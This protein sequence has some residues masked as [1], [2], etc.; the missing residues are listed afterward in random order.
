MESTIRHI[1]ALFSV[2]CV[3]VGSH[4]EL[5][6]EDYWKSVLANSPMPRA[7]KDLLTPEW[8]DDKSTS[9]GVTKGGVHVSTGHPKSGGTNVNVGHGSVGVHTGKPGHRTNVGVGKG[10]VTVGTRTRKGKPVYVRVK[11]GYSPFIYNYAATETQLHD[12]PNVALFFLEKDLHAGRKMNLQF[13]KTT[14]RPAFLSRQVAESMPFS[15]NK[16]PEIL[17]MFSLNPASQEAETVKKTIEE[18]E[19]KGVE[20]EKKVC[21]TSLESMVDFATSRLGK[22]VKAISTEA[23]SGREMEYAIVGVKKLPNERGL[24]V[25]HRQE[26]AYPVFYCHETGKTAA[27]EVE[28]ATAGS[29][30]KAAAVAVCHQDTS[31][32]NPK[33]VAFRV[34]KVKPGSVPVCHFLPEDHVVWFP[35]D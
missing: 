14:N 30:S 31:A 15:S 12:N 16:L 25:C 5:P 13:P 24:V 9:V 7:V 32:W 18:C 10:G 8:L 23:E 28:M 17:K 19:E 6:S 26:Y 33:H 35:K 3:L 2:A 29:G 4:A 11:P 1:L 27:Y 20:G 34:L 22:D 21:A